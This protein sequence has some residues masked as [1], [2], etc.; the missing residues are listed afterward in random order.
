MK[1]LELSEPHELDP[2]KSY[3]RFMW[4]KNGHQT[5]YWPTQKEWD[6]M[7]S[8]ELEVKEEEPSEPSPIAS[9]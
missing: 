5:I 4:T 8:T 7:N 1:Q 6:E 2:N 3:Q 9:L